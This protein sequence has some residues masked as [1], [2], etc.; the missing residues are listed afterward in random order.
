MTTDTFLTQSCVAKPF[1]ARPLSQILEEQ[2]EE[3]R[4][5]AR[6]YYHGLK[7]NPPLL[8]RSSSITTPYDD[9]ETLKELR[10][11]GNH[12]L[13]GGVWEKDHAPHVLRLLEDQKVLFT[14]VDVVRIAFDEEPS[15]S[16]PVILWIGVVPKTLS[17]TEALS[18][19]LM[20]KGYLEQKDIMDVEVELRES[21]VV[22]LA[23]PKFLD[24]PLT[25][26][27]SHPIVDVCRPLTCAPGLNI[28]AESTSWLEGA[29][30]LFISQDNDSNQIF[31][32]TA[33]HV[34]LPPRVVPNDLYDYNADPNRPR[35]NVLLLGG[36]AF[37]A[38]LKS[39][40]SAVGKVCIAID[41]VNKAKED[42][43]AAERESE[44]V[45]ANG[46]LKELVAF[47]RDI[48][49][50]WSTS[51]NRVIGHVVFSPPFGVGDEPYTKDFAIIEMDASK[52]DASN[53][54]GNVIDLGTKIDPEEFG[55][56][57]YP[58]PTNRKDFVYP[59]DHLLR[60]KGII[61]QEEIRHP[62]TLDE[63]GD[64]CLMVLKHGPA[65][66]LTMACSNNIPSFVR[67]YF[68]DREPQT[69][70]EWAILPR[71]SKPGYQFHAFSKA[72]DSGAI[73]VDGLGR[74]GGLLTGGAGV[75]N[76]SDIA[77]ATPI[78]FLLRCITE[79][80]PGAHFHPVLT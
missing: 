57:M 25:V 18:V 42:N 72:G 47:H 68:D 60:L 65:T 23:G 59:P 5:E 41:K 79:K 54:K 27:P 12:A 31:L 74:V 9:S 21:V 29:G 10:P 69:S 46:V 73:I 36:R 16:A 63:N 45:K 77:Y 32:V 62:T 51:E 2:S 37:N 67:H 38:L 49:V 6:A 56:R 75:L 30:G 78:E 43:N 53:F 24:L 11:V 26:D 22:R 44:L 1:P 19:A 8:A 61:S 13:S 4:H 39:A 64:P 28:C 14:S 17:P 15:A 34:V 71:I 35:R 66:G 58:H 48:Y 70:M 20:C 3:F 52:L 33:R 55:R 80:Y 7:S 40:E 50:N 76:S